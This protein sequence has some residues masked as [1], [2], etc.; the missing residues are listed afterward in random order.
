MTTLATSGVTLSGRGVFD[1]IVDTERA[2]VG[3]M[4]LRLDPSRSIRSNSGY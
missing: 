2:A 3:H 1:P 4:S